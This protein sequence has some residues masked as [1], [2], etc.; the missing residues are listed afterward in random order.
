MGCLEGVQH[1]L[2][3]NF[4]EGIV[5]VC[6]NV[7][8]GGGGHA[9]MAPEMRGNKPGAVLG[10]CCILMRAT[11]FTKRRAVLGHGGTRIGLSKNTGDSN[12]PNGIASAVLVEWDQ[13]GRVNEVFSFM[14]KFS[15]R[16]KCQ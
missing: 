6:A 8:L 5:N 11:G 2:P 15:T 9:L 4:I 12:W 3:V 14:A 10:H 13:K 16:V 7:D 1:L